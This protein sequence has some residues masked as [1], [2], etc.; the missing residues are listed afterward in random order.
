MI[1]I[2][3]TRL[4]QA[5]RVRRAERRIGQQELATILGVSKATI[6]RLE[7]HELNIDAVTYVR[8]VAWLGEG[9]TKETA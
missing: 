3:W 8:L 5:C 1:T 9:F 7:R 6:S 4:S 2:D